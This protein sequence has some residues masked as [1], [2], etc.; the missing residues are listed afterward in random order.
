MQG[1]WWLDLCAGALVARL[2]RRR[3]GAV[4]SLHF[5][6]ENRRVEFQAVSKIAGIATLLDYSYDS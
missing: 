4:V 3:S 5:A 2:L 1:L 6:M